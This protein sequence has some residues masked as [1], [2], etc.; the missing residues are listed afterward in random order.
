MYDI[1][2][3][4]SGPAG[5]TSAIYA[6]RA[7]KKVLVLEQENIGGQTA[8]TTIIANYPGFKEINGQ[9]FA[10]NLYEQVINLGGE[11]ELQ[12]VTKIEDGKTKKVITEES[13]YE[14]KSIIIA[15]GTKHR[16]LGLDNE[17]N[18]E[19]SGVSYCAL[20]DGAFYKDKEVGVVGG[21]NTAIQYAILLS[22]I[23][24]KVYIIQMLDD[25]TCEKTLKDTLKTK[26]NVEYYFNSEVTKIIGNKSLES[27]EINNK[28]IINIEGLFIAIGQ[29]PQTSIFKDIIKLNDYGY[30]I[31]N[32]NQETNIK[33]IYAAGDCCDKKVRQLTTAVNDG[34]IAVLNAI[35]YI[36]KSL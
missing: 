25:L 19:G 2:I 26:S 12:T 27:I 8:L 32:D 15:T 3:I 28:D 30:I 17:E 9:E 18:L 10:N 29:I 7:G 34:T 23:C 36:D 1:I 11:V 6:L 33:G 31:T 16:K 22:N 24:K 13:S 14:T 20:C 35:N 4:G 5:M 21:G